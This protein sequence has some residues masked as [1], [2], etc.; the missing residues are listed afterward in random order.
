MRKIYYI[1][2]FVHCTYPV[3]FY[4]SKFHIRISKVLETNLKLY[5]E[6][7]RYL[8]KWSLIKYITHAPVD[9]LFLPI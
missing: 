2:I 3:H 8:M 6:D 5:V 1:S 9:W 4:V 7:I